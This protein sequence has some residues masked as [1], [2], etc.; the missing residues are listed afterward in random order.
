MP[1]LKLC[2]CNS[3]QNNVPLTVIYIVFL[4]NNLVCL[5][6]VCTFNLYSIYLFTLFVYLNSPPQVSRVKN[7]S[8]PWIR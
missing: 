7:P 8:R 3:V 2:V 6:N 1:H 5:E 4:Y